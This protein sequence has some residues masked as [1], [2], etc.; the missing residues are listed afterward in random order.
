M[1]TVAKPLGVQTYHSPLACCGDPRWTF[2]R[3]PRLSTS[4][5]AGGWRLEAAGCCHLLADNLVKAWAGCQE[6]AI[7]SRGGMV[8]LK[9][10]ETLEQI[11]FMLVLLCSK[12]I[13]STYSFTKKKTINVQLIVVSILAQRDT[14]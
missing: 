5:E 3:S 7:T 8:V 13:S 12:K 10:E 1:S 11:Y 6:N 14:N 4:L 2:S 9:S